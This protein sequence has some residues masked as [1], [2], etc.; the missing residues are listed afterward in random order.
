MRST[1]TAPTRVDDRSFDLAIP[2]LDR[3]SGLRLRMSA[4]EGWP[5]WYEQGRLLNKLNTSPIS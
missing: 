1:E 2:R 3:G 5:G 4:A